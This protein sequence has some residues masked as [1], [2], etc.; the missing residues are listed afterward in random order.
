M[1]AHY[2]SSLDTSKA[3][4]LF[5]KLRLHLEALGGTTWKTARDAYLGGIEV[6]PSDILD[7]DRSLSTSISPFHY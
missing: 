1:E 7:A 3:L 5:G 6:V 2:M 4:E